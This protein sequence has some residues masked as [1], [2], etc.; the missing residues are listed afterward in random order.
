M[1]LRFASVEAG[2]TRHGGNVCNGDPG[3]GQPYE[4]CWL[5]R[6]TARARC[7][8]Y[9]LFAA[10]ARGII[11]CTW[12]HHAARSSMLCPPNSDGQHG[13]GQGRFPNANEKQ[14]STR[15]GEGRDAGET[16]HTDGV[17]SSLK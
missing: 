4:N 11:S 7:E 13:R 10:S 9:S 5:G 16:R 2:D 8:L 15:I 12:R 17:M 3:S 1:Q 14:S 6:P